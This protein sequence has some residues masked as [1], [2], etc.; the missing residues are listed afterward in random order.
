MHDEVQFL[1]PDP[2]VDAFQ[3]QAR[4]AIRIVNERFNLWCPQDID[5][6]V[7]RTWAECH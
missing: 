1:V 4:E 5:M 6:H 7:G 2:L 3:E